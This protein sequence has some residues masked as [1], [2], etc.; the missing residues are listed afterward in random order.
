MT[1]NLGAAFLGDMGEGPISAHTRQL[2]MDAVQTHFPPEIIIYRMLSRNNILKI[3]DLRL[4]EIQDRL[5]DRHVVLDVDKESKQS[6]VFIGY[7]PTYGVRPL[8]RAIQSEVLNPLSI[9]LLSDRIRDGETAK[10]RFDGPR[11]TI[12]V[13]P[14]HDGNVETEGVELDGSDDIEIEE[15]D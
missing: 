9:M 7:S 10:V 6:L 2:V 13:T 12:V 14:N 4:K 1:S 11:N 3:V 5:A 15:M 8:N